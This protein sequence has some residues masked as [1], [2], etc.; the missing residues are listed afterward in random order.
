[1]ILGETDEEK[2]RVSRL[3]LTPPR[4]RELVSVLSENLA[5]CEVSVEPESA[6][7]EG[8]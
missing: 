6:C 3:V 7:F 8:D 5:T 2:K 4:M 1:M